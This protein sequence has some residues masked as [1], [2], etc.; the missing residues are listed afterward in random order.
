MSCLSVGLALSM[1][2]YWPERHNI[3]I[4]IIIASATPSTSSSQFLGYG[5]SITSSMDVTIAVLGS[6]PPIYVPSDPYQRAKVGSNA[7]ANQLLLSQ[8]CADYVAISFIASRCGLGLDRKR[9]FP[10]PPGQIR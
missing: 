5:D 2:T 8:G 4:V 7:E 10:L 3:R 6:T 9:Q 1:G